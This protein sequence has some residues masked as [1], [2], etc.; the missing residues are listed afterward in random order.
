MILAGDS[1][2][3]KMHW[4]IASALLL[5]L[6][7]QAYILPAYPL[8][9][10][11]LSAIAWQA[12]NGWPLRHRDNRKEALRKITPLTLWWLPLLLGT[13]WK[14][15]HIEGW[16]TL[17][18]QVPL[19]AFPLVWVAG[20]ALHI[21]AYRQLLRAFTAGVGIAL[22]GAL[23][24]ALINYSENLGLGNRMPVAN[25]LGYHPLA[26]PLDM[27]ASYLALYTAFAFFVLL[28]P[29]L[30]NTAGKFSR[31]LGL[32]FFFG[33][34]F[35]LAARA[36]ILAFGVVLVLLLGYQFAAR[37]GKAR[38]LLGI[39]AVLLA[40]IALLI[41]PPRTRQRALETL[42][43]LEQASAAKETDYR[44]A[45]LFIWERAIDQFLEKP[46]FGWGTGRGWQVFQDRCDQDLLKISSPHTTA[47]M[48][49]HPFKFSEEFIL[50]YRRD[51]LE[52]IQS[53]VGSP[54]DSTW[55]GLEVGVGY[56]LRFRALDREA[57]GIDIINGLQRVG[58]VREEASGSE[59]TAKSFFFTAQDSVLK[60]QATTNPP[61]KV[62]L[63]TWELLQVVQIGETNSSTQAP[64]PILGN[65]MEVIREKFQLHNQYLSY[66]LDTGLLGLLLVLVGF[67]LM[68]SKALRDPH[69]LFFA[70]IVLIALSF[71]TEHLLLRQAGLFFTA[72]FGG[73]LMIAPTS[74]PSSKK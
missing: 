28:L 68:L 51:D 74:Q 49:A 2:L 23:G 38:A 8:I 63:G 10:L 45:R 64:P 30:R 46:I 73:L 22:V 72:V 33:L 56:G 27:T 50:K 17:A 54:S 12:A 18:E 16:A 60:L 40:M 9:A 31:L 26:E 35:L 20:P 19:W 47:S 5:A 34:M 14:P 3:E 69:P 15:T 71:L 32:I 21:R 24:H 39:S 6:P 37:F 43:V 36:Q 53:G 61:G 65:Y 44:D 48:V 67:G 57:G 70:W 11:A 55:H 52:V 13:L 58:E 41:I 7:F 59:G 62:T 1:G 42:E 25:L 66:M 29:P 4:F